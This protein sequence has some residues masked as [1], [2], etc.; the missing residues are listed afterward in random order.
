MSYDLIVIGGGPAGLMAAGR[1]AEN[2]A[3]VLLLEKN[4]NLG[5]KLLMTGGGRCNL[6]NTG[7][8][9]NNLVGKFGQNGKFLFSA[10]NK[11]GVHKTMEFFESR[12]VELKVE[13]G[14]KV[15]PK[16]NKAGDIRNCLIVYLK[17]RGVEVKLNAE[18]E[19]MLVGD[20]QIQK[21]VLKSGEEFSA[22]KYAI[23]TGGK[24]YPKTGSTGDAYGW[25]KTM[26][27]VIIE[28]KPAL[29]PIRIK[30][31]WVKDLEGLSLEHIKL[32]LFENGKETGAENGEILFTKDGLSGPVVLNLSGKI[33]GKSA[34]I[35][36][37]FEP[38]LS[39]DALGQ[40]L[41]VGL[42]RQK[43][44]LVKNVLDGWLPA[45]LV[46]CLLRTVGVEITTKVHD[47]H[48]DERKRLVYSLKNF[49]LEVN[50]MTGFDK[51]MLTKGGVG[52]K[53]VDPKTMRSKIIDNLY[54]AGEILDL[55]GPTGGY[56]L[57]M[58]LSTG[59]VAGDNI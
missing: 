28:P 21:V 49:E 7:L 51:A 58:C 26:G 13:S 27:H 6:T 52:L 47:L 14:G 55:D 15:F 53:E 45:R 11:F 46:E 59:Y 50:G 17:E 9:K 44:R 33:S 35:R 38:E 41:L 42:D 25:L 23:T 4:R 3:R 10:L 12:G 5:I 48:K 22:S 18:V 43:N 34:K 30:E 56:N 29:T 36:L 20:K 32:T 40:K 54:L 19:R 57:Q 31:K 8:D 16:S 39:T 37:D 1:A 24:S 2:G